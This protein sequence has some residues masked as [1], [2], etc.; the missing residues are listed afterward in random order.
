MYEQ[1]CKTILPKLIP[2]GTKVLVA[3][4]GG[5]DSMA[6][7]HILWR[8]SREEGHREISIVLTHVHHGVRRE[9]DDEVTLVQNMARLWK[10][11]CRVHRFDAKLYAKTVGQSFQEAARAWRYDRWKEDMAEEDCSLL[12]TAHHLGDQAETILFRL[13]RGSGTAGLGGMY[14]C[15]GSIIRPLLYFTKADIFQYCQR[16][17][18]PFALDHSNEDPIYARNRIRLELLPELE[19]NYNSRIQEVLGRT[20]ELLRWDEEYFIGQVDVAWK[21]YFFLDSQGDVCLRREVFNEPAAILS[22]LLRKAAMQVTGEPR[23]IGFTYITKIMGSQGKLGWV[24]DLP[25][26]RV[27]I[28]AEGLR[29][30]SYK[31]RTVQA[32]NEVEIPLKLGC[33][34]EIPNLKTKIGLWKGEDLNSFCIGKESMIAVFGPKLAEQS[35][36]CRTRRKG[37]KI[38]LRGVGH[39][40]LKKVFQEAKIEDNARHKIPLIA[41]GSEVLWIPG[42]R[43]SGQYP[44]EDNEEKLYCILTQQSSI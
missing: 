13:L 19:K 38:W 18:I 36:L 44:A 12:A 27:K 40:S 25:G 15:K 23:G 42:V 35:L 39:K 5:P 26:L 4:S 10:L 37:D 41:C 24:Q 16:E 34:E 9:S 14:P 21:H 1:L 30:R 11:P 17:R 32:W 43:Q 31:T 20:G 29:F 3:V 22:R 28:N 6:L 2:N 8:Y 7:S 33:W